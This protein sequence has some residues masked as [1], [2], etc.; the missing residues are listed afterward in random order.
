MSVGVDLGGNG[1]VDLDDQDSH[2]ADSEMIA[3]AALFDAQVPGFTDMFAECLRKSAT[4]APTQPATADPKTPSTAPPVRT[5]GS[6]RNNA[7]CEEPAA[8]DA[9]ARL[10]TKP[11]SNITAMMIA[12]VVLSFAGAQLACRDNSTGELLTPERLA[13]AISQIL[14]Q[15]QGFLSMS[16]MAQLTE[17]NLSGGIAM[18]RAGAAGFEN[19]QDGV[20]LLLFEPQS[21]GWYRK[22]AAACKTSWPWFTTKCLSAVDFY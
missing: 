1:G 5:G 10:R 4:S 19:A 8:Y 22:T 20:Y 3:K 11:A 17:T 12:V 18:A 7:T 16:N 14:S 15:L 2:N 6:H 21:I 13:I 9:F